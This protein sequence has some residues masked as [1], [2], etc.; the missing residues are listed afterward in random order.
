M[1]TLSAS[2]NIAERAYNSNQLIVKDLLYR[3]DLLPES[4]AKRQPEYIPLALREDYVEACKIRD[5]SPKAAATLARRCLQGMI[6]DFCDIRKRTLF[7]EIKKLREKIDEGNAPKGVSA[8][9]MDAIDA[10][11]AIGNI[12][13]HMEKEIDLIVE[14]DPGEAQSL[15]ELI[16]MLFDEWY[17]ARH[18]RQE[19]LTRIKSIAAEKAE[20]L[21]KL[22]AERSTVAK[23]ADDTKQGD[24]S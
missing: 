9:T 4:K 24:D 13:A 3:W 8:E 5:L 14:V 7:D 22:K 10:V 18:E 16:E 20:T 6:R 12:G 17:I 1:V 2:L 19:R 15:I 23:E 21:E 11:K